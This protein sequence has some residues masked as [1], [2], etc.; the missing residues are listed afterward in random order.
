MSYQDA[1]FALA[2]DILASVDNGP[3]EFT[4][5]AMA[6]RGARMLSARYGIPYDRCRAGLA[7][8]GGIFCGYRL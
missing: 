1:L 5:H 8:V 7:N 3:S 6:D 4:I 2:E